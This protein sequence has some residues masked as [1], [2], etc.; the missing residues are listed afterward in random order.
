MFGG[1]YTKVGLGVSSSSA[2]ES[3][4]PIA[5]DSQAEAKIAVKF[6]AVSHGCMV[7]KNLL[8]C[9]ISHFRALCV[10]TLVHK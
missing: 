4:T 8:H 1:W 2:N 10:S 7:A 5:L 3:T 9:N 6:R